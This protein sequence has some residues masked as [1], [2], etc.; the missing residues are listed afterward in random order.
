MEL[1]L[2]E[3]QRLEPDL[4]DG[5][6]TTT[7]SPE[8]LKKAAGH[9]KRILEELMATIYLTTLVATRWNDV[10][11]LERLGPVISLILLILVS[12]SRLKHG[13]ES[14]W[15]H[16]FLSFCESVRH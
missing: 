7:P 16:H 8:L 2:D 15:D 3:R 14:R 9:P 10:V 4:A 12:L 5:F 13:F 6:P 11:L 1:V